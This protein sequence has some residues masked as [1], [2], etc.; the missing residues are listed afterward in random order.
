LKTPELDHRFTII[1]PEDWRHAKAIRVEFAYERP[2]L[3]V[4]REVTEKI[5]RDE[6]DSSLPVFIE[7]DG[8][9]KVGAHAD[10]L[11]NEMEY[12]AMLEA[13]QFAQDKA[14]VIME[15]DSQGCIDGLTR[16]RL[17]WEKHHWRK[18]DGQPVENAD[19]IQCV[20]RKIYK[21]HVGFWKVKGHNN[22]PWNDLA[23]ASAVR[24]RNHQATEVT[25]QLTFRPV[26]DGK[27]RCAAFTRFPVSSHAN[28]YDFWPPLID[29]FG[30]GI[31][32]PEDHEIWEGHTKLS[33]PLIMGLE[34]EIVS[35][36]TPGRPKVHPRR[37]SA[38]FG[39]PILP[40]PMVTFE[41]K[42]LPLPTLDAPAPWLPP[43]RNI[44]HLE[45]TPPAAAR[46]EAPAR[47]VP[48][49]WRAQVIDEAHDAPEKEW[50]S[51]FTAEDTEYSI[52]RRARNVLGIL[53]CWIP[54]SYWRDANGIRMVM[55]N[56]RKE[57][58]MRYCTEHD[59]TIKE[60]SISEDDTPASVLLKLRAE[61][62]FHITDD[63]GRPFAMDD[64]LFGYCTSAANPPLKL[65][66]GSA[67]ATKKTREP[68]KKKDNRIVTEIR[69]GDEKTT[70]ARG[71]QPNYAKAVV[72]AKAHFGIADAVF[73]EKVRAEDDR[74]I[75]ECG[76][77]IDAPWFTEKACPPLKISEDRIYQEST[78]VGGWGTA[79]PPNRMMTRARTAEVRKVKLV[80][81]MLLNLA[82]DE[83]EKVGEADNY[84]Q[85]IA[86]A[87]RSGKVPKGWNVAISEANDERIIVVCKKGPIAKGEGIKPAVTAPKPKPKKVA[88][89]EKLTGINPEAVFKPK[90]PV[91]DVPGA[92]NTPIEPHHI[93]LCRPRPIDPLQG[94]WTIKVE[95]LREQT[96]EMTIRKDAYQFEIL[97]LDF[98]G[99]DLS[100]DERVKIVLKPLKMQDGAVFKVERVSALAKLAL[101]V[102]IWDGSQRRCGVEVSLRASIGEIVREAQKKLD[103]VVLE[104]ERWYGIYHKNQLVMGPWIQKDYELRP[105]VDISGTV[106]VRCRTGDMTVPIPILRPQRWQQIV[107]NSMPDPPPTVTQIGAREFRAVYGDEVLTYRVRFVTDS[108]GEEHLINWLPLWE[109]QKL[110]IAEAFGREIVLDDSRQSRAD[111]IFVK[112]AD[113]SL[114][115]PTF[116]RV[117][118]YTLGEDLTEHHVRVHKNET[119]EFVKEGLKRLHPGIN[120]AKI[121][122]EG[123]ELHDADPVTDWATATGSSP[124]KVKVTLDTPVQ[125]FWLWQ[126]TGLR[127]LGSED[128]DGRSRDEIW[129]S[130]QIRNPD[131]RSFGEYR[132][133]KGQNE[134]Q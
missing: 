122:F 19:L 10:T 131:V 105:N 81:I 100:E 8:A 128:W 117:L 70:F 116:E 62:N 111:E 99:I 94:S 102:N 69:C 25:I 97:S 121:L 44:R 35:R 106:V 93:K 5:F 115:D 59:R 134:V 110:R 32:E 114:P 108:E 119:T 66:H 96:R 49:R 18:E 4:L 95:I 20:C 42:V 77:G 27:E 71:L 84:D 7:T 76:V 98:E 11:N 9:Q 92:L 58:M 126:H 29:K 89:L 30:R 118:V 50:R 47:E 26:I 90:A 33:G 38:D 36:F 124:M 123:S 43:G 88:L 109:N 37:N 2:E 23:D 15:T 129:E 85:A 48:P 40:P 82:N 61:S 1:T 64:N 78:G 56:R 34:Y 120:P 113:G 127:D 87:K 67:L 68:T 3:S 31:G 75:I 16:Y 54:L 133:Y 17:R 24:G 130:I 74:I 13:L 14:F 39:A 83:M 57:V 46:T 21:M 63:K 132:M 103:D 45:W 112:S 107:F 12:W 28:I 73:I 22:D 52:E 55:T 86:L 91:P 80:D 65:L 125:K 79:P 101:T 6:Y 60:V 51:W 41:P 72:D 104:E 53:G